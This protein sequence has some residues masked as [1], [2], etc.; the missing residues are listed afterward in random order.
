MDMLNMVPHAVLL[1][2]TFF[3]MGMSGLGLHPEDFD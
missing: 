3:H 2:I 1:L